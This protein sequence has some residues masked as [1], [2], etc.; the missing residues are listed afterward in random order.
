MDTDSPPP[1]SRDF[2]SNCLLCVE[3][4]KFELGESQP[5]LLSYAS[6][7]I[8]KVIH[9]TSCGIDLCNHDTGK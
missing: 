9:D 6:P 2:Q 5:W 4:F 8:I 1:L 7:L 3:N